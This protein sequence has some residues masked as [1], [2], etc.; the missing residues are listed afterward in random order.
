[1]VDDCPRLVRVP[2]WVHRGVRTLMTR[3]SVVIPC[4]DLT[5]LQ[6][7]RACCLSG[8]VSFFLAIAAISALA[9][10]QPAAAPA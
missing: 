3:P 1:M 8:S 4:D 2:V 6:R 7:N 9:G 5:L 10:T